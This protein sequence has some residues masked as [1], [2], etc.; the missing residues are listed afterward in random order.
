VRV[1]DQVGQLIEPDVDLVGVEPV[2]LPVQIGHR[3]LE[4]LAGREMERVPVAFR[5]LA[6]EPDQVLAPLG[7]GEIET[8]ALGARGHGRQGEH[9]ERGQ[10]ERPAE[11][12]RAEHGE[13]MLQAARRRQQAAGS[14][15]RGGVPSELRA[16][17]R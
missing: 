13:R 5:D 2:D 4:A 12:R 6:R 10:G 14:A 3:R 7:R 8:L 9:G 1:A 17:L 11:D 16:V 15:N